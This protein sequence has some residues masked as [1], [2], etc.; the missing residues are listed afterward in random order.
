M[1]GAGISSSLKLGVSRSKQKIET[2]SRAG[3]AEAGLTQAGLTQAD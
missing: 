2:E 1:T 3:I